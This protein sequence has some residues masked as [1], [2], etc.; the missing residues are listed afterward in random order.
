MSAVSLWSHLTS[1]T[2]TVITSHWSCYDTFIDQVL[3]VSEPFL[4]SCLQTSHLHSFPSNSTPLTSLFSL[5]RYTILEDNSP[6]CKCVCVHRT[7]LWLT[8]N[9]FWSPTHS[10]CQ[11]FQPRSVVLYTLSYCTETV[12]S[13]SESFLKLTLNWGPTD[14]GF[15]RPTPI[16]KRRISQI[17][18]MV[19]DIA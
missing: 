7:L 2:F 14:I 4:T 12:E 19:I 10:H 11:C 18:H 15:F 8:V 13:V 6:W 1:G 3:N 16:L 9:L 17:A 5:L